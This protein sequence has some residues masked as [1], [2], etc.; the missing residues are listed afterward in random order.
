MTE[1]QEI[2]MMTRLFIL[3]QRARDDKK[4]TPKTVNPKTAPR[5]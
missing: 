2:A 3:A 5:S 4:K 1:A